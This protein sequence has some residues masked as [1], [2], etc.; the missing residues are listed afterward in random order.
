MGL[1]NFAEKL[2]AHMGYSRSQGDI[3]REMGLSP[4]FVSQIIKGNKL[5]ALDGLEPWAEM[6]RISHTNCVRLVLQSYLDRSE[7]GMTVTS[8][9][10]P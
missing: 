4:Q 9:R 5:P 2:I 1:V 3:C 10:K 7:V 8:V 6:M